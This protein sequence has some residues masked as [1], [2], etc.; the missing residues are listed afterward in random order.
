M[1]FLRVVTE[2]SIKKLPT[3][4]VRQII[5]AA[6]T[7]WNIWNRYKG[8]NVIEEQHELTPHPDQYYNLVSPTNYP[9]FSVLHPAPPPHPPPLPDLTRF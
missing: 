2:I 8:E 1:E 7:C 6:V 5:S 3:T 9:P 4:E